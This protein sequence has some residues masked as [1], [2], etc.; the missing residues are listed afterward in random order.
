MSANRC[1]FCDARLRGKKLAFDPLR[2][3]LWEVCPGCGQWNM[4]ALEGAERRHAIDVL[5]TKFRTA[6]EH[7]GSSAIGVARV[8]GAVL[9]RIGDASWRE[10]AAWRY[11]RRLRARFIAGWLGV[12]L[13]VAITQFLFHTKPGEYLL[14]L[15]LVAFLPSL[16]VIYWSRRAVRRA[17]WKMRMPDGRTGVV[18]L[19]DALRTE[20]L[21]DGDSWM[22]VVTHTAGIS[23]L[24]G[25]EALRALGALMSAMHSYGAR[26]SL[27]RRAIAFIE[28]AGGPERVFLALAKN[29]RPGD[30][31]KN[32]IKWLRPEERLALEM[33][34]HEHQERRAWAGELAAFGN[35]SLQATSVARIVEEELA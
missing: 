29:A 24:R 2:G 22:L 27:V 33:C 35:E 23:V 5:E 26:Q 30:N 34:A 1:A 21:R 31:E 15:P 17:I 4:S 25:D 9:V 7:G 3:R 6:P 13:A 18:R 28:Q 8:G 20:L 10:F 14:A 12:A 11:G 16:W 19:P 32:A